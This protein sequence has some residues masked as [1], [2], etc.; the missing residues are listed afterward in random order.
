MS[1]ENDS[2]LQT[3]LGIDVQSYVGGTAEEAP[4]A[5]PP[6]N[7]MGAPSSTDSGDS[8]NAAPVAEPTA[9]DV[10]NSE[11]EQ[12][13]VSDPACYL[14]VFSGTYHTWSKSGFKD[15]HQR[16]EFIHDGPCKCEGKFAHECKEVDDAPPE[17]TSTIEEQQTTANVAAAATSP[18]IILVD[19]PRSPEPLNVGGV[20]APIAL[21]Q[22][23]G[24]GDTLA[25]ACQRARE[26][27]K[28]QAKCGPNDTLKMGKCTCWK[29]GS[30]TYT[31]IVE[32][33]CSAPVASNDAPAESP[34]TSEE[35]QTAA[36]VPHAATSPD[37]ILVDG[38]RSP[39]PLNVGNGEAP[40]ALAQGQGDGDT[41]A[42]AC[43]RAREDLKAQAK[44]GPQDIL[45]MGKCTCWKGG[46]MTY[47]CIVEGGCSAPVA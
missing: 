7:E 13:A 33:G 46:T 35:Q 41:L 31:C 38:P 20:E 12:T 28:A 34:T 14:G 32:G 15:P 10:P 27:L 40:I 26:D 44:C 43:Q 9:V 23:Q 22:G 1:D 8:S 6:A 24:D 5:A 47:T 16:W 18:D 36:D 39:E 21:A 45:K 2:W 3:T 4:P 37:I 42:E 11:A 29:G 25:E 19:G 30:L 17:S